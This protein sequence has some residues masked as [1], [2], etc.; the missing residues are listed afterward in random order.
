MDTCAHQWQR[1]H[2]EFVLGGT[3]PIGYQCRVCNKFVN[4]SDVPITGLPGRDTGEQVLIG[5]HGTHGTCRDGSHYKK[6]I[7]HTDGTLEVIR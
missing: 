7:I 1:V 5:H 3:V 6:Q 4:Q 2:E